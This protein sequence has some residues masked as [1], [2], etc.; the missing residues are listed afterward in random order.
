[1]SSMVLLAEA[2]SAI[3]VVNSGLDGLFAGGIAPVDGPD[4]IV[5]LRE[6]EVLRRRVDAS[7]YGAGRRDRGSPTAHR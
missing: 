1:M 2:A 7:R 6:I 5:W 3:D 4:A